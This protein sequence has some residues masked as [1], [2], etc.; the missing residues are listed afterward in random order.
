MTPMDDEHH[1]STAIAPANDTVNSK[2]ISSDSDSDDDKKKKKEPLTKMSK[3]KKK[4]LDFV[5]SWQWGVFMAVVTVYTLFADDLRV[6]L[7]PKIYDDFFYT[8]TVIALALFTFEII[9]ASIVKPGY[10]PYFFFWL[11]VLA[12]ASMIADI[13]WVMDNIGSTGGG[14]PD[15]ASMSKTAR[16]ARVT[17]IVRLVRLIRLVRIVKLYKQA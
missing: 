4:G 17:R 15:A 9:L 3:F 12:T 7:L 11:D 2:T 10:L 6:L 14:A 1:G 16:A 5:E 8:L 13:G